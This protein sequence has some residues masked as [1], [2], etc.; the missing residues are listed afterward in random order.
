MED[1]PVTNQAYIPP[2]N[3][4]SVRPLLIGAPI[5]DLT[6]VGVDD[7]PVDLH[8]VVAQK[9]TVLVFYRGSW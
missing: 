3:M 8:L 7:Q 1:E 2:N 4:E 9:P 5:P 6:L